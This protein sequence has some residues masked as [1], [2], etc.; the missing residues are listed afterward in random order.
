MRVFIAILVLTATAAA[1]AAEPEL[2]ATSYDGISN[3]DEGIRY[4][5]SGTDV[6]F[7]D[8]VPYDIYYVVSEEFEVDHVE[9]VY[10]LGVTRIAGESFLVVT[11]RRNG[12]TPEEPGFIRVDSIRAITPRDINPNRTVM[13]PVLKRR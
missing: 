7:D 2:V 11:G 1:F 3:I 12:I 9:G 5:D 6:N 13:P 4:I 8:D 10:I